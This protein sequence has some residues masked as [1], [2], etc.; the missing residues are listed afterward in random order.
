MAKIRYTS[1][2]FWRTAAYHSIPQRKRGFIPS[3][4][5]E[6]FAEEGPK[7]DRPTVA[8]FCGGS[9]R[10]IISLARPTPLFLRNLRLSCC[11]NFAV[12]LPRYTARKQNGLGCI[13]GREGQSHFVLASGSSPLAVKE[14]GRT[15]PYRVAFV[16]G[17]EGYPR[18]K[19][20]PASRV[21]R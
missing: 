5:P 10:P 16:F 2:V 18:W 9:Y 6:P 15:L 8:F 11:L 12:L 17:I 1:I 19:V 3:S 21:L 14:R 7:R 13:F 20:A 4:G